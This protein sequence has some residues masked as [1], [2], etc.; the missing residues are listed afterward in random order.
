M[1][2]TAGRESMSLPGSVAKHQNRVSVSDAASYSDSNEEGL[3]RHRPSINPSTI[4]A[5]A[6]TATTMASPLPSPAPQARRVALLYGPYPGRRR[7]SPTDV[8]QHNIPHSDSCQQQFH[9]PDKGWT[10][11]PEK[12]KGGRRRPSSEPHSPG[13]AFSPPAYLSPPLVCQPKTEFPHNAGPSF[14]MSTQTPSLLLAQGVAD[15]S[16]ATV[17]PTTSQWVPRK[18]TAK[19]EDKKRFRSVTSSPDDG[20]TRGIPSKNPIV[21]WSSSSAPSSPTRGHSFHPRQSRRNRDDARLNRSLPGCHGRRSVDGHSPELGEEDQP[22]PRRRV[23]KSR[24]HNVEGS[25]WSTNRS[26][27][28]CSQTLER[29]YVV[30]PDS[31][32]PARTKEQDN[33]DDDVD[34]LLRKLQLAQSTLRTRLEEHLHLLK[35]QLKLPPNST[36]TARASTSAAR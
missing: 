10:E 2:K 34:I 16:R 17:S 8:V 19:R 6:D 1:K 12:E 22:H 35:C 20:N 18:K 4:A 33:V 7:P 21:I 23:V 29:D 3:L 30:S 13:I 15:L 32:R 25:T 36:L 31:T 14:P 27:P 24:T 9:S 28:V 26:V 5:S 11:E